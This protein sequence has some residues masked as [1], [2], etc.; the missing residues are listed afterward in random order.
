MAA[1]RI[2]RTTTRET[3]M[4]SRKGD[5]KDVVV[6]EK[7]KGG[8]TVFD[9]VAIVTALILIAAIILTDH[10]LGTEFHKGLF[11]AK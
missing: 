9:G 11:F 1:R 8:M 5:P 2:E 3:K 4:T 7:K 10:M 6:V